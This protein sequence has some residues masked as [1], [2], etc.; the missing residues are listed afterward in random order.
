MKINSKVAQFASNI[1]VNKRLSQ[2]LVQ[3]DFLKN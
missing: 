3:F 1:S 2:I